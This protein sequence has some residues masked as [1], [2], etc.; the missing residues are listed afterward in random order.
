MKLLFTL[1]TLTYTLLAQD[2]YSSGKIDMHGGQNSSFGS[3]KSNGY[4][5]GGFRSSTRSMSSFLDKNASKKNHS[6]KSDSKK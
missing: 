5:N 4:T 2:T 1:L 6:K 3:Y